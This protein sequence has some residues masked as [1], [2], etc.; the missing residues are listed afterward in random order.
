MGARTWLHAASIW[1]CRAPDSA[2]HST[3][4]CLLRCPQ[5]SST[6]CICSIV[7]P[8]GILTAGLQDLKCI[9]GAGAV[10]VRLRVHDTGLGFVCAHL[11]SG[12]QDGDDEK[13]N[14]DFHEIVR[15]AQFPPD[16][17]VDVEVLAS[18]GVNA[19]NQVRIM[20]PDSCIG[21]RRMWWADSDLTDIPT[22]AETPSGAVL[23]TASRRQLCVHQVCP[24]ACLA[25]GLQKNATHLTSRLEAQAGRRRGRGS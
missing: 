2:R 7:E 19:V 13:R 4:C 16:T 25:V 9:L 24:Y 8:T 14:H 6:A 18:S 1:L 23:L 15:R 20:Q 11:S 22:A 5:E 21:H 17:D 10:A 3:H 12:E